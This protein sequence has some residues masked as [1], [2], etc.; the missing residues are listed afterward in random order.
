[1]QLLMTGRPSPSIDQYLQSELG[2]QGLKSW[3]STSKA[4]YTNIHKVTF[5]CL[6]PGCER[7]LIHLSDILG[8]SRWYDKAPD[9]YPP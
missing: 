9:I 1:M 6:L 2:R 3:V 5:E 4:A 7:L 8:C